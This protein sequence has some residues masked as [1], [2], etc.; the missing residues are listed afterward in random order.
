MVAAKLGSFPRASAISLRVSSTSGAEPIIF[1]IA[2]FTSSS[3][4][5]PESLIS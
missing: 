5:K 4:W 1:W 2:A 3:V